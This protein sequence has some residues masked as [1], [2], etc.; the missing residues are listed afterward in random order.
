[1]TWLR[2]TY[3]SLVYGRPIVVVSGLPRSGTSMMMN[4]L[5]A[6]GVPVWVDGFRA[7][8]EQ[9][10][11]GYHELERVKDL[12]KDPDK[13]WVRAG[14]G[15]AVKVIS[16]LLEHL[17]LDNNYRVVFMHRNIHEV[18][19]SQ[20]KMLVQRGAVRD[21]VED[22]EMRRHY[23]AHLLRVRHLLAHEPA[24]ASLDVQYADAFTRA[25]EVAARVNNFLGGRLD[26]VR[27]AAVVDHNLYRNR[28]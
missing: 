2:H 26:V 9:N 15:R 13:S 25:S 19:A 6:G 16:S 18:L 21:D 7:A 8:D 12:D 5:E 23:E 27:M 22:E 28:R 4:M 20:S 24:F 17:P 1:M 11:N 14:R 3:R 10:P